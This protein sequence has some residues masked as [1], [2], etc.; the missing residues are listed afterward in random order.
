MTHIL[1]NNNLEIHVD[2]PLENY[3]FSRFDQTGKIVKVKFCGTQISGIERTDAEDEDVI[4][5]GF[6]NEFGFDSPLGFEEAKVG[7]WFHKIGVGLL[8]KTDADYKFD[9]PYEIDPAEFETAVSTDR[10]IISCTGKVVNGYGYVL[11]KE[12]ALQQSGFTINYSLENTGVKPIVTDEYAHNFTA[13]DQEL[14]GPDYHLTFPFDIQPDLFDEHVDPEHKVSIGPRDITFKNTPEA[15][16]FFG[17]LAGNEFV[18]A[19]WE[20]YN[21]KSGIG[22]RETG[23][24]PAYKVN[25][26]GWTHVICPELFCPIRV[27]PGGT[28]KWSR[29][30]QL[31]NAS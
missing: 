16:F 11:R 6:Y 24:F 15:P 4:G 3:C 30:Y 14:T 8:K 18:D 1:K 29:A 28:A 7:E 13:I 10:M 5:K 22:I 2:R 9:I 19:S 21:H 26:W 25:V 17:Y 27:L 12:I 20:L 23:N 31:F